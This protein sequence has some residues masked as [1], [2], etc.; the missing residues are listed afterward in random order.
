MFSAADLRKMLLRK[1]V[2]NLVY[3]LGSS[4]SVAGMAA[5]YVLGIVIP[6]YVFTA[7][8]VVG[9]V[10]LLFCLYRMFAPADWIN[11]T[12][13]RAFFSNLRKSTPAKLI[14][15]IL[16]FIAGATLLHMY[17]PDIVNTILKWIWL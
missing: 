15:E 13:L 8:L 17:A 5:P 11:A 12:T 6:D 16:L 14:V 1:I 10:L 9:I 4:V 3:I 2:S 7:I